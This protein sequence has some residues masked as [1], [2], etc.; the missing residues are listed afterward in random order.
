MNDQNTPRSKGM[1]DAI[2]DQIVRQTNVYMNLDQDTIIITEDRIRLCLISYLKRV[3]LKNNWLIPAGIFITI[4]IAAIT[5]DFRRFIF[6]AS[7][8]QAIFIIT[9]I[10]MFFWFIIAFYK[11]IKSPSIDDIVTELKKVS[12]PSSSDISQSINVKQV[13]EF[14]ILHALY[15]TDKSGVELTVYLNS[16]IVNNKLTIIASNDNFGDPDK[17]SLKTLWITY[18]V[19]GETKKAIFSENTHVNLP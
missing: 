17:G 19:S 18:S 6:D 12:K 15:G 7:V 8:W 5:S 14:K 4:F 2:A 11:S 1:S 3:E 10:V 16:L 13:R 9:G